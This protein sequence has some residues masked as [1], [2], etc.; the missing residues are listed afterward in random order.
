MTIVFSPNQPARHHDQCPS[1]KWGILV[2]NREAL[3]R[4]TSALFSLHLRVIA[5][6][7]KN[8]EW[9]HPNILATFERGR[10]TLACD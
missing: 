1:T 9:N 4:G 6:R 10:D 2:A 8:C 5:V 3:P 7:N